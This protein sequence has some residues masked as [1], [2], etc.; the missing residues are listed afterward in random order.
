VQEPSSAQEP[1]MVL[2]ALQRSPPDFVLSLDEIA[3][4]LR[5]L[6]SADTVTPLIGPKGE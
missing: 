3:A 2:S 5:T 6:A 4:L 1:L